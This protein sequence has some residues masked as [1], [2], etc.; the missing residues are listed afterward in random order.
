MRQ[1]S[2]PELNFSPWYS[3]ENRK[4]YPLSNLPGV[5]II[6]ICKKELE[7]KIPSF[8]DV[9]YIGM[10]VRREGLIGRWGDLNRCICRGGGYHSGG[11]RIFRDK[12]Y[13]K[14][15]H[16]K[17]YVSGIGIECNVKE[18]TP[19]DYIKMGWVAFLEYD[20]FAKFAAEVGGHP[21]YN[22]K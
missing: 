22:K 4:R 12:G 11:E 18:P 20:G 9:V 5:Y 17:M 1:V 21:K 3:W 14:N 19:E 8:S 7:G 13:Y 10:T 16:E 2:I 6:A 15:W